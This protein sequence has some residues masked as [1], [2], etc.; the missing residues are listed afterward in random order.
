MYRSVDI[1]LEE[2]KRIDVLINNAGKGFCATISDTPPEDLR[3]V[4]DTN[5]YGAFLFLQAVIPQMIRQQSGL[6][7]Q[8]SSSSGFSAVPLGSAYCAS[9]FALEALSESAR[10]EL[11]KHGIHVLVARPGVT[12]TA[13]FDNAKNFRSLNP[14]PTDRRMSPESASARILQA[15]ARRQREVNLTTETKFLYWMKRISPALV[16]CILAHYVR[17][18]PT[19]TA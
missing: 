17:A 13:F 18:K 7:I 11:K 19:P 5:F 15:A 9:K 3:D 12:D 8:I 14:F 16:D 2:F 1:V 10:L 4:L 6:V